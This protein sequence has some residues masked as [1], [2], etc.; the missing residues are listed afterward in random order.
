VPLIAGL[1]W[2]RATT[3]GALLAIGFGLLSWLS[4]EY[5]Y[6]ETDFWPPQLV[7]LLMSTFGML[8]GSLLPQVIGLRR[9]SAERSVTGAQNA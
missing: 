7:G 9:E 8:A 1:F 3:Q 5:S 6:Q 4:L 2:S